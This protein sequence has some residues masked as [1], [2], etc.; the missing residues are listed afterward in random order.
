MRVILK[1]TELALN[2]DI[3]ESLNQKLGGLSRFLKAFEGRG[4]LEMRVEIARTTRHHNRGSVFMAEAN[5][6]LPGKLL[7]ATQIGSDAL[8]AIDGLRDKLRLEIEKHKTQ[9]LRRKRSQR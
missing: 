3:K 2:P 7:R 6:R 1:G 8:V 4:E 5:L 9:L